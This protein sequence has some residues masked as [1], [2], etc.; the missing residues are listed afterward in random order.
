MKKILVYAFLSVFGP[1]TYA[2]TWVPNGG[3]ASNAALT[4]STAPAQP[5]TSPAKAPA[6]AFNQGE[7]WELVDLTGK[8]VSS[9]YPPKAFEKPDVFF[10]GSGMLSCV[11]THVSGDYS[12][13]QFELSCSS[14]YAPKQVASTTSAAYQYDGQRAALKAYSWNGNPAEKNVKNATRIEFQAKR[15]GVCKI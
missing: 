6:M 13:L 1:T 4:P 15:V 8:T 5:Q 12:N 10:T 2:Q 9:C 14:P 7:L 11:Y 3:G